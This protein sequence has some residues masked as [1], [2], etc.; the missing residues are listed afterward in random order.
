M[1]RYMT[2]LTSLA[3]VGSLGLSAWAQEEVSLVFSDPD[4]PGRLVVELLMGSITVTGYDGREV[5][6]TGTGVDS[7][8]EDSDQ[9]PQ[10]A[11]GL[12][13]VSNGQGTLTVEETDNTIEINAM[14]PFHAM[15][16]LTIRVPAQT[17]LEL[18]S[19]TG[20]I[21]IENVNGEIQI[22][23]MNGS[24][25]LQGVSGPALVENLHG[26][27]VASFLAAN[28]GGMPTS[29]SALSGDIDLTLPRSA[30]ASL[31]MRS[32]SGDVY[33][34]F[35]FDASTSSETVDESTDGR[36][37]IRVGGAVTGAINGGGPEIQLA[38]FHGNIYVRRG[39]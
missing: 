27:I 9:V 4:R 33:T 17:S 18:T 13:R 34:D 20:D 29:L 10:R 11:Q 36:R 16:N 39:N 15:N 22:Q 23:A 6:I 31:R 19:M 5:V 37:R 30:R 14:T 21:R 1:R 3:L 2:C 25:R 26:D 32:T 7:L 12:R 8:I 24:V 28:A 35:D 38:T